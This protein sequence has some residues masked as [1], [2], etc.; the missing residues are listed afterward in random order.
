MITHTY[1]HASVFFLA[2]V[3]GSSDDTG[4]KTGLQHIETEKG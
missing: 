4:C 1:T 2:L 3:T